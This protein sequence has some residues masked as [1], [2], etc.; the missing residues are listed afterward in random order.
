VTH[1]FSGWPIRKKLL[2]GISLLVLIVSTLAISGFRGVYAYRGLVRSMR[3]RI[4]ERP[5]ARDLARRVSELRVEL[6]QGRPIHEATADVAG[7]FSREAF[8]AKLNEVEN[9]LDVYH[10]RLMQNRDLEESFGDNRDEW[11]TVHAMKSLVDAVGR[12]EEEQSWF[13]GVHMALLSDQM[14]QLHQLSNQLPEFQ[15]ERVRQY[16]YDVRAQYR[17]WIALMWVTSLAAPLLLFLLARLFYIWIFQPLQLLIDGSRYV[18]HG[19]FQHRIEL[20]TQDEMSELSDAMNAMTRR[21]QDI[22]DDLDRQVELR[23]KQ[24][25]RS[26]QLASVGFL[27]AGVAHEINNPLASISFG[28]ESLE[29]RLHDIIQAD[30]EKEDAEHNQEIT[31]ARNYLRMIQDEA[32][33]C[34]RITESLLDFSRMGDSERHDVDLCELVQSVIDMTVHIGQ[35]KGKSIKFHADDTVAAMVNPQ[36]IKQVVLNLIT[37]ALESVDVGG[38]V[39]VEVKVAANQ[40]VIL[41]TDNGCGMTEE[42]QQH[43]FDPFFTRRRNGKG[44]GLGLSISYRIISEHGGSID[45]IS[46]GP[47]KGAQILVS[48][49]SMPADAKEQRNQYQAA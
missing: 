43:L 21:F 47:G 41:V 23:T 24:V 30:D 16:T 32:F 9:A 8:R 28:A 39:D 4:E 45:V 34:K 17:T 18:A 1:M 25:V 36:E 3:H 40:A 14:E 42:V 5:L 35:Y 13:Q 19:N 33:R 11:D 31:V 44:T 12:Q 29:M 46:D 22:R 37:N 38:V 10:D 2:L 15:D 7:R 48:L 20:S 49:P 27:A 6:G 26:E